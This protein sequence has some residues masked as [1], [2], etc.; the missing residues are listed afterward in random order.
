MGYGSSSELGRSVKEKPF[1][2]KLIKRIILFKILIPG[3]YIKNLQSRRGIFGHSLAPVFSQCRRNVS[4]IAVSIPCIVGEAS[5]Y[6]NFSSS[7]RAP[8]F[9]GCDINLAFS[10]PEKSTK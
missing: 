1:K 3:I 5:P 6:N 7:A 2:I 10:S 4:C 8:K 9:I